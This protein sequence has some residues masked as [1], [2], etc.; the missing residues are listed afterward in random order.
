[1]AQGILLVEQLYFEISSHPNAPR[2]MLGEGE[3]PLL[4]V[5]VRLLR[6]FVISRFVH[7]T[8][9]QVRPAPHRNY[10]RRLTVASSGDPVHGDAKDGDGGRLLLLHWA[11]LAKFESAQVL[12]KVVS[13]ANLRDDREPPFVVAPLRVIEVARELRLFLQPAVQEVTDYDEACAAFSSLA[14][15]CDNVVRVRLQKS[16]HMRTARQ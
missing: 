16:V 13:I 7:H 2:D 1:V 3:L 4:I 9:F 14:M 15:H 6:W 11:V 5:L 12:F 10:Q 8:L